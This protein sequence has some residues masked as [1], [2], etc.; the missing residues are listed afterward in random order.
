M[1]SRPFL[2]IILNLA[3]GVETKRRL[4]IDGSAA[5]NNDYPFTVSLMYCRGSPAGSLACASFC[6]GS[7]IAPHVVLTAGH[8][9]YDTS[10]SAFKFDV[11]SVPLENMFVL[12]GSSDWKTLDASTGARLVKA[13]KVINRGYS[14]NLKYR[15]DNDVGL[16]FLADCVETVSGMIQ[17]IPLATS[18]TEALNSCS[19]IVSLGFGKHSAVPG[20]IFVHDGKL[21]SLYGD[22]VHSIDTCQ[23]AYIEGR[24]REGFSGNL[25]DVDSVM[26]FC[27][28]GDTVPS[29]CHGDSGGPVISRAR[30]GSIHQAG[31]VSFGGLSVCMSS[32]DYSS[33][34]SAHSAWI[35]DQILGYRQ[36][37]PGWSIEKAFSSWPLPDT[38]PVPSSSRCLDN[39]W[40]CAISGQCI[41]ISS[42]CDGIPNCED[43]SDEDEMYC[44]VEYARNRNGGF[45]LHNIPG[46]LEAEFEALVAENVVPSA[47]TS[48]GKAKFSSSATDRI[49]PV[50]IVGMLESVDTRTRGWGGSSILFENPVPGDELSCLD[51]SFIV[52]VHDLLIHCSPHFSAVLKEI[53]T[54]KSSGNNVLSQ[55]LINSCSSLNK[56]LSDT[57]ISR[58]F[59]C[60]SHNPGLLFPQYWSMLNFCGPRLSQLLMLEGGKAE[61]ASNFAT[62]FGT[63]CPTDVGALDQMKQG[64]RV[65]RQM[66]DENSSYSI[67]MFIVYLC[68]IVINI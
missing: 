20:E 5:V 30:D 26:H 49:V 23:L 57:F 40:Q 48:I 29:L 35:R 4:I 56:C 2:C 7:L 39:K 33:R 10:K 15:L 13:V 3:A 65:P 28:G 66:A 55:V 19:P 34:V 59:Q 41:D 51:S 44:R 1:N 47:L 50:V 31:I 32:P 8:C 22:T 63:V 12:M 36:T 21:R 58:L 54:A 45:V 17:T 42:V 64:I 46:E 25:D 27:A 18:K 38:D 11:P 24:K 16:V 68:I 60:R 14:R 61:Y 52:K 62:N 53:G 6:S 9:V 43:N 67:R 37:C